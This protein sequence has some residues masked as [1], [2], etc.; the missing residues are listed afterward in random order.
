MRKLVHHTDHHQQHHQQVQPPHR[1]SAPASTCP[2]NIGSTHKRYQ[3]WMIAPAAAWLLGKAGGQHRVRPTAL[4]V[5]GPARRSVPGLPPRCGGV[6]QVGGRPLPVWRTRSTS[7]QPNP[8]SPY[9]APGNA[10]T[11]VAMAGIKPEPQT[12]RYRQHS[13]QVQRD[14]GGE[15]PERMRPAGI[16]CGAGAD[17]PARLDG[18]PRCA[19]ASPARA[20]PA[21]SAPAMARTGH[22]A[23][24]QPARAVTHR[25]RRG[26]RQHESAQQQADHQ[27]VVVDASHHVQGRRAGWPLV[28]GFGQ[29]AAEPLRQTRH[30]PQAQARPA[31]TRSPDRMTEGSGLRRR[32]KPDELGYHQR[33]QR[34][35]RGETP[36]RCCQPRP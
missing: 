36:P 3:G 27:R 33:N 8:S 17:H 5:P 11:R 7:Q 26:S 35:V 2:A 12:A 30:G 34:T 19:S 1:P 29:V 21:T 13:A 6:E 24:Q 4:A 23:H 32:R 28:H 22:S 18:L 9:G 20:A 14:G 15:R 10:A 16:R 31:T 25:V